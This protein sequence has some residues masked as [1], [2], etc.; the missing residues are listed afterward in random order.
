MLF[1]SLTVYFDAMGAPDLRDAM[2]VT[3]RALDIERF[4]EELLG[5]RVALRAGRWPS[6]MCPQGA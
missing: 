3:D 1:R 6:G 4:L 2:T 5:A